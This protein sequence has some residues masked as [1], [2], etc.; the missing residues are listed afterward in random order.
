MIKENKMKKTYINYVTK[1]A[2]TGK[3]VDILK[4]CGYEGEFI[5]YNQAIRI[6]GH[7]KLGEKSIA[8]LVRKLDSYD[9]NGVMDPTKS[10]IKR[11]AVFHISQCELPEVEINKDGE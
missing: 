5:T 4:K 9:K 1:I 3:N 10:P 2:Y 6:G 7:V 8:S 11:F